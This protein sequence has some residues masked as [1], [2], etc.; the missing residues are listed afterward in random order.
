M[1]IFNGPL[2]TLYLLEL[3]LK[4]RLRACTEARQLADQMLLLLFQRGAA[5]LDLP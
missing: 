4:E 5:G 2:V 1:A 3:L